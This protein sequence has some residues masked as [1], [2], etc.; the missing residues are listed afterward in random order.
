MDF[1]GDSVN[2]VV[3]ASTHSLPPPAAR[4]KK[5]SSWGH[6]KPRQEAAPP[7]LLPVKGKKKESSWGYP[8]LRQ[9]AAPPAL[10]PVKGTMGSRGYQH[11]LYQLCQM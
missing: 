7:A 2:R 5:E 8:N 6:P 3:L 9:E 10:L 1:V 4:K 11:W